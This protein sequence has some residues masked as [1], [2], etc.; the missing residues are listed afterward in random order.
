M[1]SNMT[2]QQIHALAKKRAEAK[3]SFGVHL[4]VYICVNTALVFVWRFGT[5]GGFPWFVFP[6]LG[7]GIGVVCHYYAAYRSRNGGGIS[8][9][10]VEKEAEKIRRE[11]S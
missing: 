11:Q 6:R 1:T 3:R 7:W 2:E 5:G 4:V 10:A 9:E 8:R